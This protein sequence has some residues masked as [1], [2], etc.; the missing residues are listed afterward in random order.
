VCPNLA[1]VVPDE[2][3]P[4]GLDGSRELFPETLRDVG[5]HFEGALGRGPEGP[6]GGAAPGGASEMKIESMLLRVGTPR[7]ITRGF[8]LG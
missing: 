1:N 4:Q 2:S 7:G 6:R 3:S 5:I 8:V